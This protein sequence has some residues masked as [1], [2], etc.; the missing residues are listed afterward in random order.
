MFNKTQDSLV[1]YGNRRDTLSAKAEISEFIEK[2]NNNPNVSLE[3]SKKE[4]IVE[5]GEDG[6]LKTSL[7]ISPYGVILLE[8]SKY[9]PSGQAPR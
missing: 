5:I 2:I 1:Y 3:G 6:T 8:V 4:Q 9:S 7:K